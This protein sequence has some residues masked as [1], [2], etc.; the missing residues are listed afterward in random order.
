MTYTVVFKHS[1]HKDIR[2]IPHAILRHIQDALRVLT[3]DPHPV[4][5]IKLQKRG[6]F[7]RIRVGK[8]RIIYEVAK[9]IRIITIIRIG[10]RKN[11]YG[12]P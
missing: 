5:S 2:R 11:V 12:E 10:H 4:G 9:K 6:N 1:V 3:T 7:Y 8:Y